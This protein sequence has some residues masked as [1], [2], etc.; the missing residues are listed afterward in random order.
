VATKDCVEALSKILKISGSIQHLLL[1][2]TNIAKIFTNDFHKSLGENKTLQSLLIDATAIVGEHILVSFAKGIAMNKYKNGSLSE[3]S[4]KGAIT[5]YTSLNVFLA[6][7]EI[8]DHDHEVW[9]GDSKVAEKMKGEQLEKK[10]FCGLKVLRLAKVAMKN[11]FKLKDYEKVLVPQWPKLLQII[12]LSDLES[13]SL[14]TCDID[15]K[16]TELIATAIGSNPVG[17]CKNLTMLNLQKNKIR[18]GARLLKPALIANK[19]LLSLDLSENQL[20]VYGVTLIAEALSQ[21]NSIKSLNLFKNTLDVVGCR[22]LRE[23]LKVNSSLELLDIGHNRIRQKGLEA[24]SEGLM[25]A[26][27]SRLKRLGL[28]MNF[29]NDDS[30]KKFFREVVFS[31]VTKLESLY[32]NQNNVSSFVCLKLR[33]ELFENQKALDKR[34]FVDRFEKLDF[35]SDE[36]LKTTVWFGPM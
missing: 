20:G 14:A 12:A 3:I 30:V 5:S 11:G 36:R 17:A 10:M 33:D 13:L 6:G 7:L 25:E 28:R 15:A 24:I 8:S 4:M 29:L 34:V 35:Q 19:S 2:Q 21:N 23:M 26:K 9:Y 22:A 31:G 32:I 1:G 16:S 27:N 18:D